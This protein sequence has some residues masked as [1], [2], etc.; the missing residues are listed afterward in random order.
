MKCPTCGG[1]LETCGHLQQPWSMTDMREAHAKLSD[2]GL[3]DDRPVLRR[4]DGDYVV[5]TA[6]ELAE[7]RERHEEHRIVVIAGQMCIRW[8]APAP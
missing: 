7:L 2:M 4:D 1:D 5:L 6:G 8:R 3:I